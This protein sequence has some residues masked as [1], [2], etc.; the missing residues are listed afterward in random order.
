MEI[1]PH[2]CSILGFVYNPYSKQFWMVHASCGI[3]NFHEQW[4]GFQYQRGKKYILTS[5]LD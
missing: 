1:N 3:T 4:F 2:F 5:Q